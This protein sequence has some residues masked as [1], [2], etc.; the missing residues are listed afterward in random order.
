MFQ[1]RCDMKLAVSGMKTAQYDTK[2]TKSMARAGYKVAE[3]WLPEVY[4]VVTEEPEVLLEYGKMEE[5]VQC[6]L[7]RNIVIQGE[8]LT[9]LCLS[10]VRFERCSFID[11]IFE[12]AEFGNV[13]FQSCNLSGS[14]FNDSFLKQVR[15]CG[16]KGTGTRFISSSIKDLM[17]RDC[18]LDYSNFNGSKLEG[19]R[20][21][22]CDLSNGDFGQ[23]RCK[24][25]SWDRVNLQN[26]SF[27]KTSLK[28]MDFTTSTIK[29][30]VLSDECSE[31]KGLTVDLYQAAEL[32]GRLGVII[33]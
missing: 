18:G 7:F 1:M 27:F 12:K 4:E 17:V 19:V 6:A 14:H 13:M 29:G 31:L 11:C 22:D 8:D 2:G 32:A 3:L 25:V 5:R 24:N 10:R 28:G 9:G 20:F 15:L 21:E 33:K 26:T 30:L 16:S 23:C